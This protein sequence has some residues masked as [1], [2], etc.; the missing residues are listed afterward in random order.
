[1]NKRPGHVDVATEVGF[2]NFCSRTR[3]L[4]REEHHLGAL[5]RTIVTCETCHRTLSSSVGVASLEP[6]AAEEPATAEVEAAVEQKPEPKRA[7]AKRAPAKRAPA[8]R[9]AKAAAK[10]KA[11]TKPK[12][13]PKPRSTA[14]RRTP[15]NR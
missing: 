8:K 7:P 4:R 5:V 13:P 10:P 12:T 3:N 6:A 11:G 14:T 15:K 9:V 2:C 1:M